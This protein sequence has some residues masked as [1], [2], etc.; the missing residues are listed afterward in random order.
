MDPIELLQ[1]FGTDVLRAVL[2]TY[3]VAGRDGRINKQLIIERCQN[4]RNFANKL[5]NASRFV[6]ESQT[7][8]DR[9]QIAENGKQKTED[10]LKMQTE[11]KRVVEVVTKH[12]E[13]FNFHLALEE[14]YGSFGTSFVIGISRP[15]N[16][17]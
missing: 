1:Q 13:D 6:F 7:I 4:Y 9:R 5:W 14:I 2:T 10:D 12:L 16:R 8:G 3:A 11:V 17:A 15:L